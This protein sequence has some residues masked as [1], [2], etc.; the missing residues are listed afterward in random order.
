MVAEGAIDRTLLEAESA[1]P[2]ELEVRRALTLGGEGS[3]TGEL[4]VSYAGALL[5]D[6]APLSNW[7]GLVMAEWR[8]RRHTAAT[9]RAAAHSSLRIRAAARSGSRPH[10]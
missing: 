7:L 10:V 1:R 9:T 3:L 5:I 8:V 2:F 4:R 6:A